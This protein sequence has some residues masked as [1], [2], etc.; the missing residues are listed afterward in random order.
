MKKTIF[1]VVFIYIIFAFN[2]CTATNT[3]IT[4]SDRTY[5]YTEDGNDIEIVYPQINSEKN[6]F[7]S[8][9]AIIEKNSVDAIKDKYDDLVNISASVSYEIKY[10]NDDVISIAFNGTSFKS[11][12]AYPIDISSAVTIDLNEQKLMNILNYASVDDLSKQIDNKEHVVTYGAL[13]VMSGEELKSHLENLLADKISGK[14]FYN[15]YIDDNYIY[16]I[17]NSLSH[18]MGDY[19]VIQFPR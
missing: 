13:Q 4:A 1:L 16:I 7:D 9:N 8:V 19:S 5:N 15:Y 2:G 10:F 6:T 12:N 17:D 11:E 3:D 14:D 18:A